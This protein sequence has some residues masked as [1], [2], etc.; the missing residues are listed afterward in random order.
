M[1]ISSWNFENDYVS[2][3]KLL[4]DSNWIRYENGELDLLPKL[5]INQPNI[6]LL[7]VNDNCFLKPPEYYTTNTLETIVKELMGYR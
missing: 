6:F 3:V 5:I 7:T 2:L 4:Q 1:K